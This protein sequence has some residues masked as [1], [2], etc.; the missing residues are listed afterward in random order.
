MKNSRTEPIELPVLA[1]LLARLSA[2]PGATGE[3]RALAV[4]PQASS[5]QR[6]LDCS[7]RS[8]GTLVVTGIV[9]P[10]AVSL[11][12]GKVGSLVALDVLAEPIRRSDVVRGP[13]VLGI[14]VGEDNEICLL[15]SG[16]PSCRSARSRSA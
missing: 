14:K 9:I 3:F 16:C 10:G 6:L 13:I 8:S 2:S 12:S 11:M 4:G 7:T 5:S 15:V 1:P